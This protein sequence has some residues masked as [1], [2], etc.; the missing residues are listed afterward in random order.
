[1]SEQVEVVIE[2]LV[3]GG[4]GLAHLVDGQTVFVP[5]VLPGERVRASIRK[6]R[7][8][9]LEAALVEVL[10][11]SPDRIAPPCR[12]EEQCTGATWPQIAYPAQLRL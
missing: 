1:M 5:G 12:G 10:V 2:K 4:N 11:P 9:V 8:G 6:K 3:Y 7:K